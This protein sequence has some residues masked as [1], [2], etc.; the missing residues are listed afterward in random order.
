[1][2]SIVEVGMRRLSIALSDEQHRALKEAAARTGKSITAIIAESLDHFGI[3][4]QAAASDLVRKAREHGDL[5]AA[6]AISLAVT[7]TR[8]HRTGRTR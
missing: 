4:T 8:R 6:R 3:K 2:V 7:E 5:K 1:M